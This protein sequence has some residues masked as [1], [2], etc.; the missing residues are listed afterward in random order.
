MDLRDPLAEGI[1]YEDILPLGWRLI[2]E[3]PGDAQ[4][5]HINHSNESF[6]KSFASLDEN[7]FPRHE[8]EDEH[9]DYAQELVRL[10][11]KINLLLELVGHVLS[12]QLN[13]PMPVRTRMNSSGIEWFG[14]GL[15]TAGSRVLLELY[16]HS[17]YPRPLELPGSVVAVGG[18]DRNDSAKIRFHGLSD[19]LRESLDKLIFRHHRRK[20]ASA[21]SKRA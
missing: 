8:F 15:P 10:D 21:R 11:L 2:D 9:T 3:F 18:L 17:R 20:I 4:L 6:L 14:F 1:V 12:R 5:E 7:A 19:S 16:L 13:L